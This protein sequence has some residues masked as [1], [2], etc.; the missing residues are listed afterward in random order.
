VHYYRISLVLLLKL[1]FSPISRLALP[2]EQLVIFFEHFKQLSVRS[3]AVHGGSA[4]H[5]K[6]HLQLSEKEILLGLLRVDLQDI[7]AVVDADLSDAKS[8]VR[9]YHLLQGV[10]PGWVACLILQK[11]RMHSKRRHHLQARLTL[12]VQWK[13]LGQLHH[14]LVLCLPGGIGSAK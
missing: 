2:R 1:D 5:Q 14:A 7:L 3:H 4:I 12:I 8:V 11:I 9:G 13:S 10:L 6:T